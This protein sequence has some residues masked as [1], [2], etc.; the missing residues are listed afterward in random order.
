MELV[1]LPAAGTPFWDYSQQLEAEHGWTA[2][3][4]RNALQTAEVLDLE[5]KKPK[6][7]YIQDFPECQQPGRT[8]GVLI[9]KMNIEVLRRL[10]KPGQD[11][12]PSKYPRYPSLS[13]EESV[14]DESSSSDDLAD[15]SMDYDGHMDD[16]DWDDYNY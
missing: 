9:P 7:K 6:W 14:E 3:D 5:Y 15:S 13:E 2:V 16:S 12:E 11:L 1:K 4:R 10:Y 8:M